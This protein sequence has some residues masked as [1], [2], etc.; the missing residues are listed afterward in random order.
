MHKSQWGS[1]EDILQSDDE[2]I[3]DSS[4]KMKKRGSTTSQSTTRKFNPREDPR[5]NG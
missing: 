1:L 4:V 2:S 5:I 3:A